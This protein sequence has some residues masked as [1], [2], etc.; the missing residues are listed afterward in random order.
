MR[1]GRWWWKEFTREKNSRCPIRIFLVIPL[2]M[3]T[4]IEERPQQMVWHWAGDET[5]GLD[6][7]QGRERLRPSVGLLAS[8]VRMA[9]GFP[10]NACC[11]WR[12]DKAMCG[13]KKWSL[14]WMICVIHWRELQDRKGSYSSCSAA[15]LGDETGG[16]VW[17]SR[18]SGE[19]L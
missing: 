12:W 1:M 16:L 7:E 2:G 13:G 10:R 3:G 14:E 5:R 15:E 19:D 4:V 6:M 11:N 8:L 9:S 18:R 17:R